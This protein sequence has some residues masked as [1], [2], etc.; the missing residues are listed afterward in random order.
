[1]LSKVIVLKKDEYEKWYSGEAEIKAKL[2]EVMKLPAVKLMDEHGCLSCH[3]LGLPVGEQVPLK[4][5]FGKKQIVIKDGKEVEVTVDDAYLR[6]A[7]LEP[8]KEVLKGFANM[9]DPVKD[10]SEEQ[11]KLIIDFLKEYK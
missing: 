11:I 9:M 7:I 3:T 1:M 4:G 8:G 5:I 2:D 10:L 6:R